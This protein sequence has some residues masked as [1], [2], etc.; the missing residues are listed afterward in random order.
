MTFSAE[1]L[2]LCRRRALWCLAFGL[3]A[4]ALAGASQ[5][6]DWGWPSRLN[7]FLAGLGFGGVFAAVLFW[8]TPDMSDA[9]PTKLARRYQREVGIAMGIHVLAMLFWKKLL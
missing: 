1:T 3:A 2:P 9:V 4:F 5:S 6:L 7:G 8:F